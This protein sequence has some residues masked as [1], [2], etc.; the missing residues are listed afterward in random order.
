MEFW[1]PA[2]PEET[3]V[4]IRCH[5]LSPYKPRQ[6]VPGDYVFFTQERTVLQPGQALVPI[7]DADITT[8]GQVNFIQYPL[9]GYSWY[10]HSMGHAYSSAQ[11]YHRLFETC[12][13]SNT[14]QHPVVIEEGTAVVR[15]VMEHRNVDYPETVGDPSIPSPALLAY[16]NFTNLDAWRA[17]PGYYT[18][19]NFA[20]CDHINA[21]LEFLRSFT[22]A[23]N[24]Q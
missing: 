1:Y 5:H 7:L 22:Q 17:G 2:P 19:V 13:I 20:P 12:K 9:P 16:V 11:G 6:L 18:N 10:H 8:Y 21:P 15:V 3:L 24:R 4:H 14:H 23:A